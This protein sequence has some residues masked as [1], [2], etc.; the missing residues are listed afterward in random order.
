MSP[1]WP[2]GTTSHHSA[3]WSVASPLKVRLPGHP[4]APRSG[5][6]VVLRAKPSWHSHGR[7]SATLAEVFDHVALAAD[8]GTVERT[9]DAGGNLVAPPSDRPRDTAAWQTSLDERETG[10]SVLTGPSWSPG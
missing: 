1:D 9:E 2:S 5:R 8:V 6:V 3:T 7:S 10:W 4:D